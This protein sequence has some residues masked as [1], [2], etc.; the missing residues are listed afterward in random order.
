MRYIYFIIGFI[1]GVILD[2][3]LTPS[4][5]N[6]EGKYVSNLVIVNNT[7]SCNNKC[8]HIHHWMWGGLLVIYSAFLLSPTNNISLILFGLWLGS[9][10]SEYIQY[11]NNIFYVTQECFTECKS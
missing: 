6:T 4:K 9:F 1:V 3:F 10:I 7:Q 5:K 11:G 8:T 2:L